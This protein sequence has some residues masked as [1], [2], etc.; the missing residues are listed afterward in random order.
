MQPIM[1]GLIMVLMGAIVYLLLPKKKKKDDGKLPQS[2]ADSI[3]YK[4]CYMDEDMIETDPGTFTRAYTLKDVNFKTATT[5]EQKETFWKWENL[6][7]SFPIDS[8]FQIMIHNHP[9]DLKKIMND[10]RFKPENDGLNAFRKELNQIILDKVVKGKNNLSQERYLIASVRTDDAEK[11]I[12][13]LDSIEEGI[14]RTMRDMSTEVVVE[15]QS[16]ETRLRSLHAIYN[17]DVE[18]PFE[19]AVDMNGKPIFSFRKMTQQGHTTKDEIGNS[20]MFFDERKNY[21]KLGETF[22]T[23]LVLRS[24]PTKD[25]STD[26]LA[27][28]SELPFPAL[29]SIHYSPI[30]AKKVVGMA[31]R[32]IS[33]IN[34]KLADQEQFNAEKGYIGSYTSQATLTAKTDAEELIDD[35]NEKE[36]KPFYVT[37]TMTVFAESEKILTDR[38]RQVIVTADSK[39]YVKMSRAFFQMEHAF[40]SSLPLCLNRINVKSLMTTESAGVLIPYTTME[41]NQKHGVVYGVNEET[42]N[43]VSYS[44]LLSGSNHNGLYFGTSGSGKTVAAQ[45]EMLSVYARRK[46]TR[47]QIRIIDPKANFNTTVENLGGQIIVLSPTSKTYI[48]PFDLDISNDNPV[49]DK[50]DYIIG[51]VEIMLG[52]NITLSGAHRSAVDQAV[53]TIYR[54]YLDHMDKIRAEGST[55]TCD[56]NACPTLQNFYSALLEQ[57]TPESIAVAKNIQTYATGSLAMFSHRTNI[58]TNADLILYDVSH[59]GKA[60]KELALYI[61]LNDINNTLMENYKKKI[62]TWFYIDEMHIVLHSQAAAKFIAD[63][64]MTVRSRQGVPTGI[65]QNI[66]TILNSEEGRHILQTSSFVQIFNVESNI[67]KEELKQLLDIPD[68]MDSY[69]SNSEKGHGIIHVNGQ[70]IPFD[71]ELPKNT[72]IYKML[73]TSQSK[74]TIAGE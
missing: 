5:E 34:N 61:C 16:I 18:Y 6:L 13:K 69:M 51:M 52:N 71:N 8:E 37:L 68:S 11:A 63:L 49:S 35:I 54:G 43:I 38:V 44:R 25:L 73:S 46:E 62:W 3:P 26:F 59:L 53:R 20:S 17:Q 66:E 67:E 2:V 48:N 30:E 50:S 42:K 27:D 60:V 56:V 64:W 9:A 41:I 58:D 55:L 29:I 28:L 1:I 32:Q 24:F 72:Q 65:M 21:F 12:G 23:T 36:L 74:D 15:R 4:Y 10:I 14:S 40:N 45:L 70:T 7:D 33:N 19:N 31:K 57:G 47:S 22:G 39:H